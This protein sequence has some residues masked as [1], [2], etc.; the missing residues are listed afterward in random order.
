MKRSKMIDELLSFER[1]IPKEASDYHRI[2]MLLSR[3]ERLG[4]QPPKRIVERSE[5][6]FGAYVNIVANEWEDEE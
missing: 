4:M 3:A 5:S 1:T 6:A 2:D